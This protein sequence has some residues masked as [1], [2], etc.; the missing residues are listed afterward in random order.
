MVSV[1]H[2]GTVPSCVPSLS[3]TRCMCLTL[4]P[5][6]VAY[7]PLFVSHT[8]THTHTL[9]MC[10]TLSPVTAT[11]GG[12]VVHTVYVFDTIPCHCHT[13]WTCRT[14]GVCV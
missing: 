5:V 14:H 3:H 11:Q 4:S 10:L 12:C 8:H 13:E 7:C 9:C 6:T 1:G 2:M